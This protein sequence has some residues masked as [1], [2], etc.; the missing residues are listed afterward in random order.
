M[1]GRATPTRA[2]VRRPLTRGRRILFSGLALVLAGVVAEMCCSVTLLVIG[3]DWSYSVIHSDQRVTAAGGEWPAVSSHQ[4]VHPY[5]G[6][7]L[8]PDALEGVNSLGFLQ[9]PQDIPRRAPGRTVVA[10]TGGSVAMMLYEGAGDRLRQEIE[11]RLPGQQVDICCLAVLGHKQPQQIMAV[12]YLG[13]LGAEFDV[14]VNLDGFNEIAFPPTVDTDIRS[15][16]IQ[17]T[18]CPDCP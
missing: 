2:V 3:G 14:V 6:Y 1:S 5:V 17:A 18:G 7:V 15:I 11:R 13:C 4:A 10:L 9:F 16:R 12:N 8:D